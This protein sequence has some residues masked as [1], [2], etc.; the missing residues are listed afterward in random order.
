[1]N[2]NVRKRSCG[3]MWILF[4]AAVFLA[5]VLGWKSPVKALAAEDRRV[6]PCGMPIGIY[7]QTEGVMVIGTSQIVSQTGQSAEPAKNVV[8]AGDYITAYNGEAVAEKEDLIRMVNEKGGDDAVLTVQRDGQIL[9]VRLK[10]VNTAPGEY[11]LGIWVRDDTQGIGTMT[12]V[13]SDGSFGALGHGISDMDTGQL[14]S[15]SDGALY[16]AQIRSIIKGEAGNPGSLAGVICYG[17][18]AV[19]GQIQENCGSGIFGSV[20]SDFLQ[21][22][23]Q[24]WVTVGDTEEIHTGEACIRTTLDGQI[25]DYAVTILEM[26]PSGKNDNKGILLQVTDPELLE[27]TGGIVQGM[28]GSPILQDGKLIGAVTHVLV[29]DSTKGYG[30]FI[31]N[32]L[33]ASMESR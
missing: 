33:E 13:E 1:M 7:M 17:Q 20:T 4:A 32:M 16:Q 8:K 15:I 31:E 2:E 21:S 28:S 26:D 6:I 11:K 10:P 25:R 27:K 24:N 12:Y 3:R 30:I 18:D 23:P 19:C 5:A 9:D 14:V 22:L 29:R